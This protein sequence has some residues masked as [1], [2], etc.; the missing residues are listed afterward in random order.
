MK[1]INSILLMTLFFQ[2]MACSSMNSNYDCPNSAGV[3]CKSVDQINGMVDNGQIRGRT[4]SISYTASPNS[5]FQSYSVASGY[6]AGAP[7][8]YGETVQR[9]WIAPFEDTEKNYHQDSYL[10]AIIKDGHW[11]GSPVKA[12]KES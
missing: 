9:I 2:L 3:M 11:I 7:L 10:Y 8:R 4:Q 1:V 5:E 6:Y 12:S